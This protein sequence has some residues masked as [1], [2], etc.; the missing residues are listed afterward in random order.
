MIFFKRILYALILSA[1]I[2]WISPFVYFYFRPSNGSTDQVIGGFKNQVLINNENTSNKE[3]NA[4]FKAKIKLNPSIWA[5]EFEIDKGEND[6][7]FI[8]NAITNEQ[9]QLLGLVYKADANSSLVRSVTNPETNIPVWVSKEDN[10]GLLSGL[11]GY[12]AEVNWL[13]NNQDLDSK[14]IFT[15]NLSKITAANIFI[16]TAQNVQIGKSGSFY[17]VDVVGIASIWDTNGS[18]LVW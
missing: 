1:I 9:N 2:L 8:G 7:V 18:V 17:R 11:Y 4:R 5:N 13:K 16:G 14:P 12:S 15:T 3:T 10:K 6:N